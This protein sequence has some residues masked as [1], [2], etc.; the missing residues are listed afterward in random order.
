[1][2]DADGEAFVYPLPHRS[3]IRVTMRGRAPV[4]EDAGDPVL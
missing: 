1:L 4:D 2:A 3:T